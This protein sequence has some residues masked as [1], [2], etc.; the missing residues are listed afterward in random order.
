MPE[1]HRIKAKG[2]QDRSPGDRNVQAVLLI[3]QSQER[4]LVD[5]E[6]FESVME[7]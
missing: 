1:T 2:A 7:D 3:N 5:N 6:C 4:Y